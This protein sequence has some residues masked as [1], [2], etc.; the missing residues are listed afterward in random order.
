MALL[1][2]AACQRRL[3]YFP[4]K[5]SPAVL[6]EL[7]KSAGLERWRNFAGQNIGWKR[8]SRAQPATGQ[9]LITH[10]N[11][12]C[13]LDRVDY[14][15]VIDQATDMDVLILEYPGFGDRP[16]SPSE[17]ELFRA[18]EEG[19]QSILRTNA[20][21]VVGESLGTGVAAYLAGSHSAEI[22]GML[23][24][25]PYNS[26]TDVA[27]C[28]VPVLP[29]RWIL[30]DRFPSEDYL[31]GY[32]GPVAFL[33]AGKDSVVPAKFGRR[34]FESYSGPKRLWEIPGANHETIHQQ[35]AEFWREVIA[36]WHTNQ[37]G[38]NFAK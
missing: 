12:G 26:L 38:S 3:I 2:C 7:A 14:A 15:N 37:A 10:G 27:Q 21:Y 20:I 17:S 25:A 29:V 16:G 9:V 31:R 13:A 5:D 11:A 30:S 35:T 1:G 18:A 19:L 36:F 28:H 33:I 34:L 24:V 6:D 8:M 22:A 32:H 23:L 4:K